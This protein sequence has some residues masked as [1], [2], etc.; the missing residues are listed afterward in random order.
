MGTLVQL[1]DGFPIAH[2]SILLMHGE[3]TQRWE[4]NAF[5]LLSMCPLGLD[6]YGTLVQLVDGLRMAPFC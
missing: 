5:L 6:S 3:P 2:G 1:V 4:T